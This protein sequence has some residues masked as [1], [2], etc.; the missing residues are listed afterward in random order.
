MKKKKHTVYTKFIGIKKIMYVDSSHTATITLSKP[1]KGLLQVT[2]LS[3][4][5]APNRRVDHLSARDD[6]VIA[7]KFCP[8]T[9]IHRERS[10]EPVRAGPRP[11]ALL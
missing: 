10:P 11:C 9:R 6:C 5:M 4:I 8:E 7:G 3:G 1:Y 2:A